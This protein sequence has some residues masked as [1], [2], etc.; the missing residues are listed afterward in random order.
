MKK[1]IQ[2]TLCLL[3]TACLAISGVAYISRILLLKR[4]DGILTMQ[5]FYAQPEGSVDVLMVGN[6]HCG[7]NID[8]ARLWDNYG[9][10]SY[11]LWGG[12]QPLWNSYHFLLEALKYQTPK[13]VVLEVTAA[14]SDYEYS[15]EQNQLK[16]IA[17]MRFSRN[18]IDAVKVTAPKD[19]W[20]NLLLGF[21]LYHGR[22]DELSEKDFAQFSWSKGLENFKGSYLL[23][24]VGNYEHES[25]ENITETAQIMD[26]EREYLMKCIA[27]CEEKNI[28]LVLLKTPALERTKEQEIYNTL[29]HLADEHSVP[30]IN[31]NLLDDELGITVDDWSL[32]RHMNGYGARKVADYLGKYLTENFPLV[33][34]R[35]DSKYA[36]WE[37]NAHKVN[38]D[39]IAAIDGTE[40]YFEELSHSGRD[41]VIIKNS[42]WEGN[43]EYPLLC[44]MLEKLGL[45]RAYLDSAERGAWLIDSSKK[46]HTL[47][48]DEGGIELDGQTLDISFEYFTANLGGKQLAW[49]GAADFL[50]IVY[51]SFTHELVD[52]TAFSSG[53]HYLPERAA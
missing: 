1:I 22:F 47:N 12:V 44:G 45:E 15:E 20:L 32:D 41:I 27:L 49:F 4:V 5:D 9:L 35:G 50:C 40:D 48:C 30:F 24:G 43:A 39:F 2:R 8:T 16:N 13:V 23:Y 18:K 28:P 37:I 33:D 19:R 10:S 42:P 31:M 52:V 53:H 25:A 17:G 11:N 6:S 14:T 26:K 34:H 51:D 7:I 46:P 38:N 21:P 29:V 36:S 3:L